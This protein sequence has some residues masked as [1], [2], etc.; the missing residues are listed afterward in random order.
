MT[1][2]ESRG[3]GTGVRE[4]GTRNRR[5]AMRIAVIP[6]DGIG[7]D[8]TA[9]AVKVLQ[10]RVR[11]VGQ[12]SSSSQHLPW[13]ADHYLATG[14]TLPARRLPDA[15]RRLRRGAA[16]R[17]R[18]SARARQ[19]ARA[20]HPARHALRARPL[21]QLPAGAA[22]R[23]PA[24]PAQGPRPSRRGL[25][26]VPREHR[27]RLRRRRRPLQGGHARR[28][29]DPGGDQHPQGR[30]AHHPPRLRVRRGRR[31]DQ[32]VHGRQVQRHAARPRAVAARVQ[33]GG[34][35]VSRRSRP[36]TSTSTRWRCTWSRIPAS[37]R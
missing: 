17:P 35:R 26:G 19:P 13:S 5:R 36:R 8:V 21:R 18:R 12:G 37:S 32:G 11:G 6:G 22:A 25:R 4:P 33:G 20:R 24:L 9:E 31:A 2:L 7:K 34:R 15:A 1:G 27:G 3:S 30:G 10:R 14:E 23:R 28:G 29:R 16:R